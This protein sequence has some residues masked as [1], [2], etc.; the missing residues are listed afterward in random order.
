MKKRGLD[1]GFYDLMCI[2][3]DKTGG[4]PLGYQTSQ[5]L[6]LMFLDEFDHYI[7]ETRGCRYYGRY[8][9]D[10]YIIAPTKRE[11]QLLLKDI[12]RWMADLDLE[13]NSKTAIFP[14][15][16]GLD[17]LGF[18]SYLTESGAC[19]QKLRRSEI[20]RI[21]TRVKYWEKA[22]PAGEVTREAVITSFVAWDAFASYGDTYALRLK[23]AKKVSVIIGVDVKPRR[24]INSTRSVRALRR[25]KQ[26]QNIRRKRGD[27]TPRKDLFQPEPRPDSIPPW[28]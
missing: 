7:K 3:I 22:Y 10:F 24:K 18:H 19:V 2:Y 1:M 12:E 15:K 26:E 11:L 23:Y 16:N 27:I 6:A 13:L 4:L 17:F 25:V 28:M 8:M 20:Q 9:D 21:Q 14:L 5:L